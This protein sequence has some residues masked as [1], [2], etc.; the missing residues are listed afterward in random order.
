MRDGKFILDWKS[1]LYEQI[2][3]Y[4]QNLRYRSDYNSNYTR[5]H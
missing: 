3:R 5:I 2:A 1:P 4:L